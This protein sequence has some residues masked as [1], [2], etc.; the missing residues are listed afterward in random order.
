MRLKLRGWITLSQ[1]QREIGLGKSVAENILR[2]LSLSDTEVNKERPWYETRDALSA[3]LEE[4]RVTLL[5]PL[6]RGMKKNSE[7]PPWDY[8]ER[9]WYYWVHAFASAYGWNMGTVADL[10]VD[11]AIALMQEIE[12]ER[13]LEREFEYSISEV[14]YPYDKA[15]KKNR[16]KPMTRPGWMV[17]GTFTMKPKK[18]KIL[19]A[20]IPVGNVIKVNSDEDQDTEHSASV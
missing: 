12:T 15:S 11:D 8:P 17:V 1:Y 18:R 13:Q 7:P 4:N 2:C 19:K 14:A 5:V 20:W 6:M 3:L 9:D 16:F 10:E